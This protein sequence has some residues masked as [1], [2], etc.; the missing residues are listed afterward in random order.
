M[1]EGISPLR[2]QNSGFMHHILQPSF[3][4]V[5]CYSKLHDIDKNVKFI[6]KFYSLK[7][8]LALI[9]LYFDFS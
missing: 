6:E 2:D 5:D 7:H 9:I 3:Y 4:Q 8:E 1:A